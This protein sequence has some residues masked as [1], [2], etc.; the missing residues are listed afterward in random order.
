MEKT[1]TLQRLDFEKM[2][3]KN[4]DLKVRT[5]DWLAEWSKA[6]VLGTSL[7]GGVGSNPTPVIFLNCHLEHCLLSEIWIYLIRI[8]LSHLKLNFIDVDSLVNLIRTLNS[9]EGCK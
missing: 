5:N 7:F 1:Q 2:N 4:R 3:L 6:L 8:Q 9:S